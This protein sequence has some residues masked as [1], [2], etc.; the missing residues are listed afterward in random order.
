MSTIIIKFPNSS[1]VPLTLFQIHGFLFLNS[2]FYTYVQIYKYN[3]LS[4]FSVINMCMNLG[5]G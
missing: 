2:Y 4:P 3:L 5:T 1:F